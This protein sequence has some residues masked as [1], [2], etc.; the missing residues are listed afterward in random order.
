VFFV[1]LA[2]MI[3]EVFEVDEIE[4]EGGLADAGVGGFSV[5]FAEDGDVGVVDAVGLFSDT[6]FDREVGFH[7][8]E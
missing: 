6:G 2:G 8:V 4:F 3:Q 5:A 7:V 1:R